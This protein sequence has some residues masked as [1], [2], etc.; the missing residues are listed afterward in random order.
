MKPHLVVAVFL[1]GALATAARA[2][3]VV[4]S[5]LGPLARV[6]AGRTVRILTGHHSRR[7]RRGTRLS[8]TRRSNTRG[9]CHGRELRVINARTALMPNAALNGLTDNPFIAEISIDRPVQGTMERTA[10]TIGAAAI[11]QTFGY[12]GSGVGVAIIDSGVTASHDDLTGAEGSRVSEFVDLVNGLEAAYDDYGHGTHVAGI[13]GGNGVLSS[14]ARTGIAPGARMMVL[15]VLDA[16]GSGRISDVI[17]A[18]DRVLERKDALNIRVVN[19]SVS[20][21]VSRVVRDRPADARG[22]TAGRRGDR[23]GRRRRQRRPQL[24]R[25]LALR[26]DHRAGQR[27]VGADGRRR[28]SPGDER[29]RGRHRRDLQLARPRD[30]HP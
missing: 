6:E 13:V 24:R 7:Q 15:K 30:V 11:R 27:A 5:K 8:W 14:G 10:A 19:L 17:A 26:R 1:C 22:E 12:D 2:Q 20:A 4:P 9:G 23:R 18:F 25:T 16:N 29:S 3:E 28:E 21:A